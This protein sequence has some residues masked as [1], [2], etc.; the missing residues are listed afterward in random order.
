MSKTFFYLIF[1]VCFSYLTSCASPTQRTNPLIQHA[2]PFYN[3]NHDDYP[4]LHLPLIKPIEAKRQDGRTP[5]RVL[6]PNG[7]W[8]S[9]PN[10]Q[11]NF[12]YVYAI[13]ELEKFA[14]KNGVIMAYSSY[15]DKQADPYIQDNY[16]HWFVLI[17]D[18]K[19]AEGFHTEDEFNQYIQ[20]LGIQN[21]DWQTPDEAFKKF[22]E[23]GCLEWIPDCN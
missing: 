3:I 5:W 10:R 17:P 8:V 11:D 7:P 22:A 4:L 20:T 1:L 15:V 9:V 16:Y 14:I 12:F 21:L 18:K 2:D 13:E 19:I 6:S 23:T